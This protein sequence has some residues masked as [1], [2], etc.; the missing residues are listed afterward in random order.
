[1]K[2]YKRLRFFR[3]YGPIIFGLTIG[4]FRDLL[5]G[6]IVA[7]L[8][9]GIDLIFIEPKLPFRKKRQEGELFVIEP[10]KNKFFFAKVIRTKI[11]IDDPVMNGGHLVYVFNWTDNPMDIPEYLDPHNLAIPP[12][13]IDNGGWKNGKFQSVGFKR[14]SKEESELNYGFWDIKTEKFVNE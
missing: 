2:K 11:S 4:V 7:V 13:I 3:T 1:M 14:V 5:L 9:I 12:Q 6:V 8:W 10:V